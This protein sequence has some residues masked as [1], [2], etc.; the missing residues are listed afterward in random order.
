MRSFAGEITRALVVLALAAVVGWGQQA[1][2]DMSQNWTLEYEG[3]QLYPDM[4]ANIQVIQQPRFVRGNMEL[5]ATW[6]VLWLDRAEVAGMAEG[7]SEATDRLPELRERLQELDENPEARPLIPTLFE[8]ARAL[9]FDRLVREIYLE[10]PVEF[11]VDGERE[12]HATAVYLD[13]ILGHGWIAGA[14]LNVQSDLAD[15]AGRIRAIAD[16]MRFSSDGSIQADSA[17]MTTSEFD[18]PPVYIKT[19]DLRITPFKE[20][21]GTFVRVELKKNSVNM[22][23]WIWLPLPPVTFDTDEEFKPLLGSFRI[24]DSARFGSVF[25]ASFRSDLGAVGD[26]INRG[27]GGDEKSYNADAEMD[28]QY[29]SSRGPFADV[30]MSLSSRNEYWLRFAVGAVYDDGV[31]RGQVRVQNQP[32]FSDTYT[33]ELRRWIRMRGRWNRGEGE[34][35]DVVLSSQSD[36][37]VQAE[38]WEGEFSQYEERESYVHWRRANDERYLAVTGQVRTDD[39]RSQVDRVPEVLFGVSRHEIA[40]VGSVPL[41]WSTRT[42][43]ANLRRR[44]G[45]QFLG[46]DALEQTDALSSLFLDAP[47]ADG[48]GDFEAARFDHQQ[49]FEVPLSLGVAGAQFIPFAEGRYTVWSDDTLDEQSPERV[50]VFAGA[51]LRSVLWKRTRGNHFYQ[52]APFVE[53]RTDV[54]F[55]ERGGTP[56]I[57]DM[58][59]GSIEGRVVRGGVRGGWRSPNEPHELDLELVASYAG[60]RPDGQPSKWLPTALFASLDTV[61]FGIPL[62][63]FQDLRYDLDDRRTVYSLTSAGF[64]ISDDLLIV[65]GHRRAV[66]TAY[67]SLLET[68]VVSL[69]YDWTTKWQFEVEQIFSG[70][71]DGQD[72]TGFTVRRF[73]HDF[74]FDLE[75]AE[76]SGEGGSSIGFNVRPNFNWRQRGLGRQAFLRR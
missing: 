46:P 2:L 1:P 25:G 53:F 45:E 32:L 26:G 51:E 11:F 66:D 65:A 58:T 27:F 16:W 55:D 12:A 19:K 74:V 13:L 39:F 9:G 22:Y 20:G 17:T 24:G 64:E 38:F 63:V 33:D 76:R 50:G 4:D 69:R 57:F 59:E 15:R 54:G 70:R 28:V 47:F 75:L 21:P 67:E 73:G 23:D 18:V 41:V 31:D 29:L 10:G 42:S 62:Q 37:G 72:V 36:P 44:D 6:A 34:W 43:G 3:I 61:V 60:S 56:A 14:N 71:A 7:S 8:Q 40:N 30:V 49:R 68:A 48:P 35:F 5:R 52:L